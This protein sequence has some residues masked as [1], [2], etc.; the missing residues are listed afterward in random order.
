M[1]NLTSLF[2]FLAALSLA[3][4]RITETIKGLPILSRWL[5][6]EQTD[7]A[8][9]ELR[10]SLVRIIAIAVGTG[11]TMA[12]REQLTAVLGLKIGD[13][14]M[15]LIFGA[16][17]SGGSSLWNSLLDAIREFN[18]QKAVVTQQLLAGPRPPRPTESTAAAAGRS[19][20]IVTPQSS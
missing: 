12:A 10:K 14:W 4:E 6:R 17:A 1:E 16:M 11:L 13:W 8:A 19:P 5:A 20:R 3:T 15:C 2:S 7:A 18:K 9:E